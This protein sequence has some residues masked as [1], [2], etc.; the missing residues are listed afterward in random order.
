VLLL[1]PVLALRLRLQV[2]QG[3]EQA[4]QRWKSLGQAQRSQKD[5]LEPAVLQWRPPAPPPALVMV[6]WSQKDLMGR[7]V[8][9]AEL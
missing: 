8:C 2:Q 6:K 3:S 1:V 9:S 4:Q 5:L 7:P